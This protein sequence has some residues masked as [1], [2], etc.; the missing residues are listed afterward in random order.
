MPRKLKERLDSPP[1]VW[2]PGHRALISLDRLD[3]IERVAVVLL[4]ARRDRENVGIEDDVFGGEADPG[5]QVV[6]AR[7]DLDLALFGVGLALLVEG[8]D[9]HRGAIVQALAG[10]VEERLLAFLHLKSS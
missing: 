3:E 2:T 5:E 10:V 9:H 8:H 4:H 6:G 1:E 7:A